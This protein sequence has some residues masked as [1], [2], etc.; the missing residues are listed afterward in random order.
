MRSRLLILL[1]F[2]HAF[3]LFARREP[4][5]LRV[6]GGPERKSEV[7]AQSD[8]DRAAEEVD[9]LQAEALKQY[10]QLNEHRNALDTKNPTAVGA[11]NWEAAEYQKTQGLLANA[12]QEAARLKSALEIIKMREETAAA[13]AAQTKVVM[14]STS[15]CPACRSAKQYFEQKGIPFQE[16][17]VEHSQQ[18][19]AEFKQLG[20]SGVPLIVINGAKM[21]GFSPAWVEEQ[22]KQ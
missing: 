5:P 21:T 4:A 6:S 13:A 9:K 2:V 17:D 15:W 16:I 8:Y 20:G 18:G 22:L 11:F 14:Y 1:S 12:Q 10:A 19:A 7:R 3:Y